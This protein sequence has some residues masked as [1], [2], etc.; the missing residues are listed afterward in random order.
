MTAVF[1]DFLRPAAGHITAAVTYPHDL[2]GDAHSGVIRQLARLTGAFAR[3]AA[4]V[5]LPGEFTP[6]G[7]RP[8]GPQTRAARDAR[9]ALR[10]AA[11][12][13]RHATDLTTPGPGDG[14]PVVR[15]LAAAAD[16]LMAG[17]D[18]LHTHL[19]PS[20]P[21]AGPGRSYWAP[22]ITS[23]PVTSALL[24]EI[25]AHA[26]ALAPW[27]ARLSVAGPLDSAVPAPAMVSLHAAT[28]WLWIAG[29][30][31]EATHRK[32]PPP[33]AGHALLHAIPAH[34]LP[35]R[36]PPAGDEAVPDLCQGITVTAERLRHLAP[37]AAGQAG[38]SPSATS[39]AWR[40]HALASAITS[41]AAARILDT[42]TDA[43]HDIG[44]TAQIRGLL[45]TAAAAMTRAWP[46]WREAAHQWDT[47]STGIHH[48]T[49]P[50]PIA[51]EHTDLVLRTGRLAY[52]NPAWTPATTHAHDPRDTAALTSDPAALTSV[53][54]ALHTAADAITITGTHDREAIRAAAAD[55][56]LY[57]S[58]LL[59]PRSRAA[60]HAYRPI[61]PKRADAIL[62]AYDHAIQASATAT[63]A[64][65]DLALALDTPTALLATARRTAAENKHHHTPGPWPQPA[66][67][68]TPA[69]PMGLLEGTPRHHH[70]NTPSSPAHPPPTPHQ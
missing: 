13:L 34:A 22:V 40:H 46:A 42:L 43:A 36:R 49:D 24:A 17:R 56:R 5:P 39:P 28:R 7:H 37:A 33:A 44:A 58:T 38:W 29:A 70:I 68:L 59:L 32:L 4:D 62:C 3:Y 9:I 21:A 2:P 20:P 66:G 25:A 61:P 50:I 57:T 10:R 26:R 60:R 63:T 35:S 23:R 47:V 65:E 30:T 11:Q 1:G 6:T 19:T 55:C 48:H 64:L 18:L 53:A 31:I 14:H 16:Y 51:A 27:A 45:Q 12:A 67:N 15:H 8:P 52:G 69:P 41:H 54:A